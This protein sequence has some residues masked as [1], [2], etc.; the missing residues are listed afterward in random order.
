MKSIFPWKWGKPHPY[1]PFHYHR[2]AWVCDVRD[3]FPA[4]RAHIDMGAYRKRFFS[5]VL[6]FQTEK[7]LRRIIKLLDNGGE[8][9][10]R[11]LDTPM[12]KTARGSFVS[13]ERMF[14][15]ESC[16]RF[17]SVSEER[18]YDRFDDEPITCGAFH[19]EMKGVLDMKPKEVFKHVKAAR[20]AVERMEDPD[21][22]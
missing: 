10:H 21:A 9:E 15:C 16:N 20:E 5:A 14:W 22:V 1:D 19:C 13:A 8:M 4:I 3:I 17:R 12:F 2:L 6:Y 7:S 11:E 18:L